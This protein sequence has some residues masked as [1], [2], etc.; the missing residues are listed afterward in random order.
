MAR[1]ASAD[2][3]ARLVGTLREGQRVQMGYVEFL[4]VEERVAKGT[5]ARWAAKDLVAHLTAWKARRLRQLEAVTRGEAAD[6]LPIQQTNDATWEEL[7]GRTWEAI[8]A[9]EAR[10]T[11][12]LVALVE[13]MSE[14]DLLAPDRYPSLPFQPA[15]LVAMRPG[16]AHVIQ[17]LAEHAIEAGDLAGAIALR[18]GAATALDVFPEFPELAA[19]P[20]Y[21][22]ALH[23]VTTGQPEQALAEL[24]RAL[25]WNPALADSARDDAGLTALRGDARF[26]VLVAGA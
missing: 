8:L 19:A 23:Y 12:A 6:V 5:P 18:Q 22:L 2:L 1:A 7:A 13:G 4:S 26:N 14:A 25:T 24:R 11:A 15:A 17:H 3:K 10:V 9:E 21:N 20:H 16:Y